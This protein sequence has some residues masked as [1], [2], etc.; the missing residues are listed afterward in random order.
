MAADT[1]DAVREAHFIHGTSN[2]CSA[3]LGRLLTAASFMGA[4]LKGE[5]DSVTLRLN[6]NGPAGSVIAVSDAK[7]NVRGYVTHPEATLPIRA[8]DGKLDVGGIVGRDGSLTVIK[9]LGMRDPYIG[10]VPIVSG[11]IAEDITSYFAISEQ[12][13]TV[14]A[15]GVLCDP[16][17][18]NILN[19]GGF[20]IQLLPTA[21]DSTI[22]AVEEG[23]QG[24]PSVTHLLAEG[25]TPEEI[26]KKV[27]PKFE[28]EVLERST[29]GYRC[30]CSKER[31]ERALISLG[32]KELEQMAKDE[33][34]EVNCTFCHK[35][36]TFTPEEIRALAESSK[37]K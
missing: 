35:K 27:L 3:A 11:E 28:M 4:V 23:L 33:Q 37:G 2:V 21:D 25:L 34:T 9:D 22:D 26:C 15:L 6:G 32:A 13:P 8:A 19:A 18:G 30:N 10:Q 29:V 36:Y 16:E 24:L 17:N 1:T 12:V 5:E 31:V 7:G 20:L 14:C